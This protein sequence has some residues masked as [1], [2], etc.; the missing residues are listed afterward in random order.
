MNIS[1][2]TNYCKVNNIILNILV[3][4]FAISS[5]TLD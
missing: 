5:I 3:W 1:K 4:L 2:L